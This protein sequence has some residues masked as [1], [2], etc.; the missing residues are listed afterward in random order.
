M[1]TVHGF[2]IAN[3]VLLD[4]ENPYKLRAWIENQLPKCTAKA[5]PEMDP[6]PFL[7]RFKAALLNSE[8]GNLSASLQAV[9]SGI[10]HDDYIDPDLILVI[11]TPNMDLYHTAIN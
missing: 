1:Y 9:E 8:F 6:T 7:D 4:I 3:A 5:E 11:D 10:E 2:T